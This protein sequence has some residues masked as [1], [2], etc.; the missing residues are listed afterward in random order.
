MLIYYIKKLNFNWDR[1][2]LEQKGKAPI[3]S[4]AQWEQCYLYLVSSL[5]IKKLSV[6]LS[7]SKTVLQKAPF[8]VQVYS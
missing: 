3:Y 8:P 4:I 5:G 7:L 6:F 2:F 1:V